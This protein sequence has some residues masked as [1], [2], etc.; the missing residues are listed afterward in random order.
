MPFCAAWFWILQ[1]I[2]VFTHV[3]LRDGSRGTKW[4]RVALMWNWGG[5]GESGT[6]E[7]QLHFNGRKTRAQCPVG[8]PPMG[9][10]TS[11]HIMLYYIELYHDVLYQFASYCNVLFCILLYYIILLKK[12]NVIYHVTFI[13]YSCSLNFGLMLAPTSGLSTSKHFLHCSTAEPH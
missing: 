12:Y 4:Q 5:T 2:Y 11:C 7:S 3:W 6:G 10:N 8:T 13:L 9:D 1:L